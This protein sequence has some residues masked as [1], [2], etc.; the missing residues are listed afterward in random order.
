MPQAPQFIGSVV[1]STQSVPQAVW[2]PMQLLPVVPAP[3]PVLPA[4]P[5]VPPG[6][7]FEQATVRRAKLSPTIQTRAVFMT[8]GFPARPKLIAL[9]RE[10][11]N[12]RARARPDP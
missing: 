10:P 7:A 6:L 9:N 8:S 4:V 3:P 12:R 2:P 5:L 11:G 1:V